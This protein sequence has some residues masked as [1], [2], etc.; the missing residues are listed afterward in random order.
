MSQVVISPC[1]KQPNYGLPTH[2][3][4]EEAALPRP[5]PQAPARV[6]AQVQA[7]AQAH[8]GAAPL[9]PLPRHHQAVLRRPLPD[10]SCCYEWG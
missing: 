9:L 2:R 10:R 6:Q 5:R 7:Q 3:R 1:S 4:T 8:P